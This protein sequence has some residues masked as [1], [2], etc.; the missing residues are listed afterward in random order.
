MEEH[1]KRIE[2]YDTKIKIL[3]EKLKSEK[4]CVAFLHNLK[5]LLSVTLKIYGYL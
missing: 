5:L 1:E 2:E 4:V 3:E